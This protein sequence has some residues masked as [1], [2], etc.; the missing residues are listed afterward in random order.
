MKRLAH[1]L[2]LSLAFAAAT[3]SATDDFAVCVEKLR[4]EA[5]GKGIAPGVFDTALAGVEPDPSVLDALDSQP[6]F[7]TAIWDYLAALVDEQRVADGRAK[8][9]EWGSV[10]ADAEQRFGV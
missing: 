2:A 5:I 10:F 8:L 9:G 1:A 7:K 4:T 3:V 6:E